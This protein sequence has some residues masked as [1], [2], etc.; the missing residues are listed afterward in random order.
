MDARRSA[1]RACVAIVRG[2][3]EPSGGILARKLDSMKR[4]I[5]L[6]PDTVTSS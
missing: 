1:G 4:V 6:A 3:W 2:G 5:A